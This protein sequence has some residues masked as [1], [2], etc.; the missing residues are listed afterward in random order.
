MTLFGQEQPASRL[1]FN[2]EGHT[3][4]RMTL[5]RSTGTVPTP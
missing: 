5:C 4:S 3:V 2:E 1:L